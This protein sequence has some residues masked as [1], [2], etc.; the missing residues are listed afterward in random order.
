MALD[1][2][3]GNEGIALWLGKRKDGE[4]DIT[5]VALLRG[6]EVEKHPAQIRLGADLLNDLTDLTIEL[7]VVLL[8]QIHSH[9]PGWSLD[10]SPTDRTYGPAVPW[11]LSVV[12]PDYALNAETRFQDCAVHVFEPGIGYRRLGGQEAGE[13]LQLVPGGAVDLVTVGEPAG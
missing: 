5:H 8:G 10:L 9:G 11:Y 3:A 12:A 6:P 1:G 7:G 2:A 13:R 4:A